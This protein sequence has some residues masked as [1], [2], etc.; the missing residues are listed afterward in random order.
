MATNRHYDV[1]IVGSGIASLVCAAELALKGRRVIVLERE[2]VAGG[3][4]RTEEVTLPGFRHDVLSMS[5][6]LFVTA[7]HYPDL[8]PVLEKH[9][10]E[11]AFAKVPTAVATPDG[12][13][14]RLTQ[15]RAENVQA[16]D[17]LAPGDGAAFE[18]AM[19]D[20][21]GNADFIFGLLGQEPASA[22]TLK[23]VGRQLFRR[24]VAGMAQFGGSALQPMRTWLEQEFKS[25]LVHALIAPWILHTGLSP[26]ST[27]S[28]LMGKLILFTLEAVGNPIVKGGIANL[29]AAFRSLIE[30]NGGVIVTGADVVRIIVERGVARGVETAD[31]TIYSARKAVVC[32]VTPTQ[33]YGRLLPPEEVPAQTGEMAR[34]YAYGRAGMQMHIALSEPPRWT[35]ESLS[36]VALIHVTAGLDAVSRAV[37][38]AE[39][40][41]LPAEPTIVVGQPAQIDPSRCPAGKSMLWIQLLELPRRIRGDAAG[42]IAAPADGR[43]N[44][45]VR[46]AY[47]QR[48][49]KQLGQYIANLDAATLAVTSLSPSDLEE[50]NLNLVDGDP[51]SGSCSIDQFHM[52]RPFGSG[53]NHAT[54]VRQLFQIG[55]STHPGHG[56]AGMSGHMVA[57]TL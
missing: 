33:L 19:A 24:R 22:S 57:A 54:P 28:S 4:M 17:M 53:R 1:V 45:C 38:E 23:L 40:G 6:P 39:R 56:L 7:A 47:A 42:E 52:F 26:E 55:A 48:I 49:L 34:R 16:F 20:I 21:T 18:R 10:L 8:G 5:L 2:Q 12:R 51:Y 3:C 30:T 15:S 43:W 31:G 11:V 35:N 44:E 37:N 25:D 32:N 9:G 36:D 46:D 27:L 13:A 50:W 29:V 14:L 41:L